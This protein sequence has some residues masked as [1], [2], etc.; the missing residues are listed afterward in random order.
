MLG[1]LI[2]VALTTFVQIRIGLL[3]NGQLMVVLFLWEII[4]PVRLLVLGIEI[5]RIKS[6]DGI[7]RTLSNVW[8]I[9]DLKKNMI[10]L[11][12]LD[13][14]GYKCSVEGG[15]LKVSKGAVV[16]IKGRL[17]NGLYLLQGSIV[18]GVLTFSISLC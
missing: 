8:H 14:K 13:A 10:S 2:Q 12:T 9:L 11:G 18:I 5:V 3:L 1:F 6:H 7:V 16:V 15:V 4:H 17:V